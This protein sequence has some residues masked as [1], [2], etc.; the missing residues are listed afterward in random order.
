MKI[1][2]KL[3]NLDAFEAAAENFRE[4][5]NALDDAASSLICAL[6]D[7]NLEISQPTDDAAR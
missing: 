2:M 3:K 4:K 5:I 6:H 7:L 1:A